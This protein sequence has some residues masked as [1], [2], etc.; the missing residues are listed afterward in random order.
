MSYK[1]KIKE[2]GLSITFI[3]SKLNVNRATF[4]GYLNG[5]SNMPLNV[6]ND[7]KKLLKKYN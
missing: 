1:K 4:S 3:A 6:E 7:L 5:V 2:N